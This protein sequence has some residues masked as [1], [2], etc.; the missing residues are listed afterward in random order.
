MTT[1][2]TLRLVLMLVM[3][4]MVLPGCFVFVDD[5]DDDPPPVVNYLPEIIGAETEWFCEYSETAND[6]FFEFVTV[7]EDDDGPSDIEY[8]DVTVYDADTTWEVDSFGLLYEGDAVWGGIVWEEESNLF[9]WCG[10]P[11]D[12]TFVATDRAGASDTFTLYYN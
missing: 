4:P 9:E 2:T 8:V 1:R 5:D 10:R 11:I 3:A 7:V 12:V 6:Y